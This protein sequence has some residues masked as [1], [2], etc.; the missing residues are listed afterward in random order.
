MN[1]AS[2]RYGLW[3]I[4]L[5]WTLFALVVVVGVFGLLHDDWPKRSQAFWINIHA[6]MGL[7]LWVLL[8]ARFWLRLKQPPPALP[9]DFTGVARRL[10]P[11]VHLTLYMLLFITPIVGIVTFIWHGRLL[12]L[13]FAQIHFGVTKNRAIFEPT[14]DLHGYL[15]YGIFALAGAHIAAALWHHF[16][17]HDGVLRRMWPQE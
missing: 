4:I 5:H 6:I 1:T 14:E 10:A 7:L 16:V 3:A 17:K 12:D 8:L 11:A 9:A 2:E 13:G 15:A